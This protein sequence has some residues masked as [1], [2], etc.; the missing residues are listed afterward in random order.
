[1][2][3][4]IR[5]MEMPENCEVCPHAFCHL[6][7]NNCPLVALPEKHGRL[8]DAVELM[9]HAGRDRLD[10]RELIY[11]MIDNAPTVIEKDDGK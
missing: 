8:I 1:M 4:L 2:S 6:D 3:V 5:N 10:S 11:Q 7:T 9:E